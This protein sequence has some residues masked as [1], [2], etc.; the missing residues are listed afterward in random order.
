MAAEQVE[1]VRAATMYREA[2]AFRI[3]IVGIL[4][5]VVFGIFSSW[6]FH[7][8]ITRHEELYAKAQQ[9]YTTKEKCVGNRGVIC[10]RR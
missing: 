3:T 7:L 2:Y 1:A 5:A 9:M 8:Q 6:F 4:L 10:D